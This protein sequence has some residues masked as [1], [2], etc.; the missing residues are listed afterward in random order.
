MIRKKTV[1][2]EV[3]DDDEEE[4]DVSKLSADEMLKAV[5]VARSSSVNLCVLSIIADN[6]SILTSILS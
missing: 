3:T 6:I 4:Y 5:V 1:T 2:N